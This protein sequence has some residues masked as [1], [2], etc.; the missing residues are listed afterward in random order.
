MVDTTTTD[1]VAPPAPAGL[2]AKGYERHVELNW[3]ASASDTESYRIYRS[4]GGKPYEWVG[5]QRVGWNRYQDFIGP[6]GVKASYRITAVDAA[7]NESPVSATVGARTRA[8]SDDD[9]MTMVQE[10]QFKYYW[11]GAH[12]KAGLAMEI[13]PGDPDQ[14]AMGGSG[15]GVMALLVGID[16][17]FVTRQQG[18]DRFPQD[19]AFP[20]DRRPLPRRLAAFPERQYRQDDGLFRQV[21]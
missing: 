9:L 17:G 10:A 15:F 18:V 16:R 2:T 1:M 12:P 4:V 21:R 20:E 11:D 14:V 7:G 6:I 3:Q 8:M 5:S 13:T 19:P